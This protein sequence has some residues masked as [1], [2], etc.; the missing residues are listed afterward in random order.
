M[1]PF[2]TQSPMNFASTSLENKYES[3]APSIP[4]ERSMSGFMYLMNL[5]TISR[6]YILQYIW[7]DNDDIIKNVISLFIIWA[8]N[9]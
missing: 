5:L 4:L 6:L 7:T 3:N 9:Q 2:I 1:P 8:E